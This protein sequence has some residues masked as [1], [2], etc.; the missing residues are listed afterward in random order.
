MDFTF[1][2]TVSITYLVFLF[3]FNITSQ[4]SLTRL[5]DDSVMINELQY[6]YA[7]KPVPSTVNLTG[8]DPNEVQKFIDKLPDCIKGRSGIISFFALDI[9]CSTCLFHVSL[10]IIQ[11]LNVCLKLC[12]TVI[13]I[14]EN[15]KLKILILEY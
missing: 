13:F 2:F 8:A 15:K 3:Q 11:S 9:T 7:P 1:K 14:R 12:K 5:T 10:R 6:H 4:T